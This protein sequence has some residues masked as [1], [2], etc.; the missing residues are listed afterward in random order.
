M[1]DSGEFCGANCILERA[2]CNF[3]SA[4]GVDWEM[5]TLD[6]GNNESA[7]CPSGSKAEAGRSVVF[8][9]TSLKIS[10]DVGPLILAMLLMGFLLGIYVMYHVRL[11]TKMAERSADWVEDRALRA[12]SK[13]IVA[14][15]KDEEVARAAST[16]LANGIDMWVKDPQTEQNVAAL[17]AGPQMIIAQELGK[18]APRIAAN[19]LNGLRDQLLY[20]ITVTMHTRTLILRR[21]MN[22]ALAAIPNV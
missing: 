19:F 9:N 13:F 15:C 18:Q 2:N 6:Y 1:R 4:K 8:G 10:L 20:E 7:L 22:V 12:S 16:L 14:L 17:V 11:V 21:I 3:V 5:R